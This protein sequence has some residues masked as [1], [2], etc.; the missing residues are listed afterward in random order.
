MK[1][2]ANVDDAPLDLCLRVYGLDR[3]LKSR[4]SSI[5]EKQDILCAAVL[6]VIEASQPE[7]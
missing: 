5:T 1:E 6:R 4:Q 3:V 2:L 7:L